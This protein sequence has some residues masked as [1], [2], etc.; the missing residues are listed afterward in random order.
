MIARATTDKKKTGWSIDQP[1][2]W[3]IAFN[4]AFLFLRKMRT[5]LIPNGN[6]NNAPATT[7]EGSGTVLAVAENVVTSDS[8][9]L[10]FQFIVV[11][12]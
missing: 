8:V 10:N 12:V 5:V 6:S 3:T 2:F 1:V 9:L 11:A 4:Q 7:V